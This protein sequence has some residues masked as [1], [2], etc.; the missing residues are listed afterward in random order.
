MPDARV[1]WLVLSISA[2]GGPC[3][4]LAALDRAVAEPVRPSDRSRPAAPARD[5]RQNTL[6][7]YLGPLPRARSPSLS[8]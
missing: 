4:Y 8:W 2:L 5:L 6:P 1:L 3:G 7:A